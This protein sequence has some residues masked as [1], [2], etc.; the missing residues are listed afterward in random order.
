[1]KILILGA[2]G[3]V[4]TAIEKVCIDKNIEHIGLSSKDIEIT[5]KNEIEES[6]ERNDPDV[7]INCVAFQAIDNCERN[8]HKSF[9]INSIAVLDLAGVC[10]KKNITLVH[11]TTHTI[12]DGKSSPYT[13]D[14]IPNPINVY[15]MSK[16]IGDCFIRNICKKYYI[17]LLPTMFGDRRGGNI[18]IVEKIIKWMDEKKVLHM[19][20]DKIDSF[21][22]TD[23]IAKRMVNMLIEKYP[24]GT[25]HLT[26]QGG[27]SYY[28]LALKIA[29]VLNK[30]VTIHKAKDSDFP[31]IGRKPLRTTLKSNKLK[32]LRPWKEALTEYLEDLK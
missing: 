28:I 3:Q 14:D 2:T 21:G 11:L 12:F 16:H 10:Q 4:G 17:F 25:Y 26:N 29:E 27:G 13:E 7:V 1:M 8:P 20:G 19:A 30:D 32:P 31:S 24:Y 22:Y 23:D 9:D 18:G 15:G 6:I 5:H